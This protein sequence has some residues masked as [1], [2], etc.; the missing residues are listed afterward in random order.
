MENLKLLYS[1]LEI[2]SKEK[3]PDIHLT[4]SH[5][6][7][8]RN[9]TG[10]LFKLDKIWENKIEKLTKPLLITECSQFLL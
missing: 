8:L 3:Y 6:P 10:E 5:F 2:T 1:I 4:T 9:L 7:I